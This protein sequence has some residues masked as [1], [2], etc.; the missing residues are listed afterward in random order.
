MDES[1]DRRRQREQAL[2]TTRII[3]GGLIAGQ[4]SF[5]L[6]IAV[7]QSLGG[8]PLH[9]STAGLMFNVGLFAA[10]VSV[11]T[12]YFLRMQIYKSGWVAESVEPR[13]Y[14]TGNIVFL[15]IFEAVAMLG[16]VAMLLGGAIW[17]YL[18]VP[19]LMLTVQVSNF[20]NG[21]AMEPRLG[22]Q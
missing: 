17:P 9:P 15:A 8:G 16:L 14:V 11:P 5:A 6:A 3:W 21:A 20:P 13:A 2:M 12:A 1:A 18:L 22:L 7:L 19:V 10:V 4:I